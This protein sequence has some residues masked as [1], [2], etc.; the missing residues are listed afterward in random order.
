[1]EKVI[2]SSKIIENLP[3]KVTVSDNE[4][5]LFRVDGHIYALDDMWTHAEASLSEGEV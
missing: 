4:V 2:E 1:M 5:A 3:L